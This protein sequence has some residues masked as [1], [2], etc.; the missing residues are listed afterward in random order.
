M[1]LACLSQTVLS[2]VDTLDDRLNSSH[3]CENGELVLL[4]L[5]HALPHR[6]LGHNPRL[7]RRCHHVSPRTTHGVCA[8]CARPWSFS[9]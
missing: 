5:L 4:D 1:E 7:G 6:V 3:A 9:G 8:S 2:D